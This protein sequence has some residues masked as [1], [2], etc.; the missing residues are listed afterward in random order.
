MGTSRS[1]RNASASGAQNCIEGCPGFGSVGVEGRVS[2]SGREFLAGHAVS[3]SIG[4]AVGERAIGD[5]SR[6][7]RAA[8]AD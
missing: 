3:L 7:L 1:S 8:T 6:R 2:D 5:A 4:D